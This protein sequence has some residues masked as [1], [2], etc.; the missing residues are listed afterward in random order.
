MVPRDALEKLREAI[1][2]AEAAGQDTLEVPW[3]PKPMPLEEAKDIAGTFDEVLDEVKHK[4]FDPERQA[5]ERKEKLGA[6]KGILG[7]D[8]KVDLVNDGPVTLL[9]EA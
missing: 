4:K 6:K 2:K 1:T 7:A 5:A 8:M 3:L 9:V